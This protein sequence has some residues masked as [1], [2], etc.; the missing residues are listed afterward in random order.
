MLVVTNPKVLTLI[1]C[2]WHVNGLFWSETSKAIDNVA[3]DES[4][5]RD[6]TIQ[7]LQRTWCPNNLCV[8]E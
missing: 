2:Q 7:L 3:F 8:A 5:E 1:H 4:N 6:T